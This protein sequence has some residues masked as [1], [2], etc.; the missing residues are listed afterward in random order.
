MN[1][2]E[3]ELLKEYPEA[4]NNSFYKSKLKG[5]EAVKRSIFRFHND[6]KPK[7]K[8]L[9]V[10]FLIVTK[11]NRFRG[12]PHVGLGIKAYREGK[13][14]CNVIYRFPSSVKY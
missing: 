11:H 13:P 7:D 3:I 9:P 2:L 14:Q 1:Q 4:I 6:N 12:S 5:S 10:A 8:N